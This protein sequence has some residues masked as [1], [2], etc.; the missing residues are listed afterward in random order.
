M[1]GKKALSLLTMTF[2]VLCFTRIGMDVR[3]NRQ[4]S[5]PMT[6]LLLLT[7]F[8]SLSCPLCLQS[9]MEFVNVIHANKLEDSVLGVMVMDPKKEESDGE[10]HRKIAEKRLKGFISGNNIQFP[11]LLDEE[12]VFRPL[13]QDASATLV[14]L[15]TQKKTV[16]KYEF[17]LN[18]S[19]LAT[20]I[21]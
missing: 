18:K 1:L 3:A 8:S 10:R 13:N 11:F 12:R 19:Q 17:P 4:D 5:V 16:E 2:A 21:N 14:V 9:F 20:I 7:D 15:N 6:K